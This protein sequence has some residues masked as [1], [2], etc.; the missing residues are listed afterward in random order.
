MQQLSARS[1]VVGETL[2]IIGVVLTQ[3]RVESKPEFGNRH[4]GLGHGLLKPAYLSIYL[5]DLRLAG[6]SSLLETL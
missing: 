6:S 2:H 4:F 5:L 3:K 1:Q